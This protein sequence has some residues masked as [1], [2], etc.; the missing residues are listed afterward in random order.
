MKLIIIALV[1]LTAWS[2]CERWVWPKIKKQDPPERRGPAPNA[3]E[4]AKQYSDWLSIKS[5]SRANA[6]WIEFG[7]GVLTPNE[8]REIVLQAVKDYA[9]KEGIPVVESAHKHGQDDEALEKRR[10]EREEARK[11]WAADV[12]IRHKR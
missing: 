1:V 6:V 9:E 10:K 2:I 3:Q 5:P 7:H 8:A 12:I 11:M 4:A